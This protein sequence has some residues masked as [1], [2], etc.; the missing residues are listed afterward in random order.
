M[1]N[2]SYQQ[3]KHAKLYSDQLHAYEGETFDSPGLPPLTRGFLNVCVCSAP[4]QVTHNAEID[5]YWTYIEGC[6]N[7]TLSG[8][9]RWY[10][11]SMK[12]TVYSFFSIKDSKELQFVILPTALMILDTP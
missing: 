2:K 1:T 3:V 8:E 12:I 6:C 9:N 10:E 4:R 5:I 7:D 11:T